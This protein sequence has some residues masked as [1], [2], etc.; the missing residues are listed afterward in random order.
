MTEC[1]GKDFGMSQVAVVQQ[2]R[3]SEDGDRAAAPRE[4]AGLI[5]CSV[6]Q[7]PHHPDDV[8]VFDQKTPICIDCP[9]CL[10]DPNYV[11]QPAG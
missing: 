1:G 7:E 8:V 3:A 11:E 5:R 4:E 9:D 10:S 2:A 6:C